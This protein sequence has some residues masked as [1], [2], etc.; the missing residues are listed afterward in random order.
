MYGNDKSLLLIA[1]VI[2][3]I[4][5]RYSITKQYSAYFDVYYNIS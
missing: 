1:I 5:I 3:A 2:F 4:M